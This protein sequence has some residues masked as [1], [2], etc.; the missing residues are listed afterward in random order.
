VERTVT[1]T[2]VAREA[3]VSPSTVSRIMNGTAVVASEKRHAVEAAI[4]R[5]GYRPN[6]MARGLAKGQSMT[7]GVITQDISS[8]F[9]GETLVGIEQGLAGTAYQPIFVSGHWRAAQEREALEMLTARSI[10]AL[11]VIGGRLEDAQLVTL[12]QNIP[13]IAI[14]RSVAGLEEFCIDIDHARGSMLGVQHL[15]SLGHR[16]I[17]HITGRRGHEDAKARLAGYRQALEA[18]GI[19]FDPELVVEGDFTERSGVMAMETLFGRT[20]HFS[21]I[22]CA[23]DQTAY[24]ARLALYRRGVRVPDDVSLV[25]FDDLPGSNYVT[26]PLTSVRQPGPEMGSLAAE[27]VL[28]MLEGRRTSIGQLEAKLVIRESTAIVRRS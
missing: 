9:Y 19:A 28:A 23:N 14:G 6:V 26:P 8:P 12:S 24:G 13:V 21:A 7:V 1:L 5:L 3:G 16:R 27:A 15:I 2:H 25:G 20:S 22:S 4:A 18:A 11:I 10:D 17:A